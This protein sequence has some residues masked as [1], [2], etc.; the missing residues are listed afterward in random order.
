MNREIVRRG[1]LPHYRLG[2]ILGSYI[3]PIPKVVD[4]L[5]SQEE[6]SF[7]DISQLLGARIVIGN[8]QMR[9][10]INREILD[11][12]IFK[13][14][15][16]YVKRMINEVYSRQNILEHVKDKLCS[17]K[18]DKGGLRDIEAVA[19]MLK[20]Y[21]EITTPLSENFFEE[22]K[23][24]IPDIENELETISKSMYFLRTVRNLYRLMVSA[25]DKVNPDYL[26]RLSPIL[27]D[28]GGRPLG[29]S[30]VI[31]NRI[32][33]TLSRSASSRDNII[34]YVREKLN[35]S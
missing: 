24:K 26:D 2:E 34:Q 28:R 27:K 10:I 22:I 31:M 21:L 33:K 8:E 16:A 35:I 13:R 20:A 17:L 6:E 5:K 14:K 11:R 7:I 18:E 19:L 32:N 12:F 25:E 3:S 29:S 15:R 9:R 4:Y 30:E 1:V 23:P